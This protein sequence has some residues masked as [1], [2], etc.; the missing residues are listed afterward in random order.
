MRVPRRL[1]GAFVVALSLAAGC[2]GAGSWQGETRDDT[3][4]VPAREGE[5]DV[6]P[7]PGATAAERCAAFVGRGLR[8]TGTT[9]PEIRAELGDPLEVDVVTEPN[10][11][12]VGAT[13]SLFALGYQ[14]IEFQIRTPPSG[15]DLLERVVVRDNRH[16]R[17]ARPGI[18]D[19]RADVVSLLGP[20]TD[21]SEPDR[22]IYECG[23]GI[24]PNPVHIVLADD[25]VREIW[26]TYYVD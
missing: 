21:G 11:H 1:W 14:G 10:R 6:S 13:D 16:L 3:L 8:V 26:Y 22:L 9:R 17:Y 18:G 19:A 23:D 4:T 7:P 24:T 25:V 2:A 20:P 15:R 5:G 12:M